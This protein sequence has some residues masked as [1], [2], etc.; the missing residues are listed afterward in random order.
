MYRLRNVFHRDSRNRCEVT[1]FRNY[2]TLNVHAVSSTLVS[3]DICRSKY[4]ENKW[5]FFA[6][7][8]QKLRSWRSISSFHFKLKGILGNVDRYLHGVCWKFLETAFEDC[9]VL[10][11]RLLSPGFFFLFLF[12]LLAYSMHK[13]IARKPNLFADHNVRYR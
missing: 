7:K 1:S 2:S 6:H 12:F 9:D 4:R 5:K 11:L 3:S 8:S 10:N 13:K